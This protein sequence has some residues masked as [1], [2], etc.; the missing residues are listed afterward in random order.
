M[1]NSIL[2]ISGM[3]CAHCEKAVIN[4]LTDISVHSVT[5]CAKNG[6]VEISYDPS[7]VSL[8]RIKAEINDMGYE[9]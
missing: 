1:E 9:C 4:A 6:T 3:S 2:Q 8:E 7:V 5:A